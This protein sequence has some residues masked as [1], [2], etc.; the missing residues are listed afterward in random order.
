MP[1][2]KNRHEM[3]SEEK[4]ALFEKLLAD[5][6][7]ELPK[8]KDGNDKTGFYAD[9]L[10]PSEKFQTRTLEN[11]NVE[12]LEQLIATRPEYQAIATDKATNVIFKKDIDELLF[13]QGSSVAVTVNKAKN[14]EIIT[15][16][17]PIDYE[18]INWNENTF[19]LTGFD[20]E[21]LDV[22]N[23]LL[24]AGNDI[25][26]TDQIYR[27]MIGQ[28]NSKRVATPRIAKMI[29]KS[30]GGLSVRRVKI[31]LTQEAKE[32]NYQFKQDKNGKVEKRGAILSTESV[33]VKAGG[34]EVTAYK[35]LSSMLY[36]GY[37]K[38]KNQVDSSLPLS[39]NNAPVSLT[40]DNVALKNFLKRRILAMKHSSLKNTIDVA[41][42]LDE[43]GIIEKGQRLTSP[44]RKKRAKTIDN[45]KKI[46]DYWETVP[47]KDGKPFIAGYKINGKKPIKSIE[48]I[49]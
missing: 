37:A 13:N 4:L 22:V 8:D 47:T 1:S 16:I 20:R 18:P 39:I 9:D 46:L 26:T 24:E 10:K 28:P 21:T 17:E 2:K 48:I 12:K 25:V 11:I 49:F 43:L 33:T 7:L 31:D 42:M 45:V 34:K 35:I 19:P 23:S 30:I 44:N 14:K 29:D 41:N 6:V 5:G 32:M 3:T 36:Q 40:A 27:C 15:T 38:I